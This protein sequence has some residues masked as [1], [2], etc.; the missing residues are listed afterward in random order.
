MHV[1]TILLQ[2]ACQHYIA[3]RCMSTLYCFKMHVNTILLQDAC[4]HYIASR[5][6]STLYCFKMHV[7]TILLQDA[8]QHYIASRCMSTLY[9]FKMHVNTILL[10]DACQ[11]YI[12]SRCMSTLYCFKMHVN[13]ILLQD[14]C[15]HYIASRCIVNTIL[16]QDACQQYIASRCMSTLYFRQG[17]QKTGITTL[18]TNLGEEICDILPCFHALTGSDF[19]K[20]FFRRTKANSFKKMISAPSNTRLLMSLKNQKADVLEVTDFVLH[21][22]YNRPKQ[23]KKPGDSRYATLFT[24]GGG[25][26]GSICDVTS[27]KGGK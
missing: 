21:I 13:T 1:N 22:I 23:E 20:T 6:M 18:A 2:D 14:A 16:L 26:G 19:T 15:Q 8:C 9:C 24:I 7:N 3:S 12:A 4:Q 11:H 27:R 5:C 17:T 25:G 10:Q